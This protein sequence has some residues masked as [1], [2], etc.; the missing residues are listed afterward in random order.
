MHLRNLVVSAILGA[1]ATAGF[2]QPARIRSKIDNSKT[3]VLQG[4]VHPLA[5]SANDQGVVDPG[6]TLPYMT[7]M[8]RSTP[9][10][11]AS[12]EQ[13]LRD[14]QNPASPK[15]HQWLTPEQYADQFGVSASDAAQMVTWLQS[16]GFTV[17]P[18][19]RSRTFITFSGTVGQVQN[20]FGTTITHSNVNG[21]MHYANASDLTIPAELSSVVAGFRGLNDFHPK[22]R[23]AKAKPNWTMGRGTYVIAPDDFATIYDIT[24]LYTAGNNGAGQKVAV[25]G[26]SAINPADINA[27]WTKFG[28]TSVKL[29]QDLVNPR[30]NPGYQT[31]TGDVDESSLDVEWAGAVARGGTVVFVYSGDVWTS[32]MYAVDQ[33][34]APVLSMSYGECEMYDLADLPSYRQ[35]VQQANAQGI[36]WLAAAGDQGATDCDADAT[37]AEGGLAVDEPGS[38]PEV[39]SMGGTA[40]SASASYWNTTNSGTFLSAK[41]YIPEIVWNDTAAA[42]GIL[43]T[44]GGASVFFQQPSWQTNG[45]VP[46]DGWRHV[47][48][49]SFN[50]SVYTVPY[51]VYCSVCT[52]SQQG[53]EYVGGTSAATPTMAGVVAL[54]NQYLNTPGLGNINPG[55]YSLFQST[56]AAFHNNITGNN[57]EPCAYA[58]PGC[59]NGVEGFTASGSGYSSAVGLGSLDVTQ[60]IQNW[61]SA[62][63]SGPVV[64]ASLDQN[65]VYQG[66]AESCG[67]A[68][69][70][71]FLLTLQETA[72]FAT[73]VTSFTVNGTNYTSQL[74]QILGSTTLGA[75]QVIQ[76]CMSLSG[77][78]APENVTFNFSGPKWS[79]SISV[80]FQGPQTQ[81]NVAGVTNAASY[82][83][84]YAPG[85]ILA[86]FGTGMGSL[87]QLASTVPLP[88]YMAGV[89]AGICPVSCNS[90]TYYP[91][92]LYY[93]GPN[94]V[95]IQIPYEVTGP[96]DLNIGNPYALFDF[97][98]TV[99]SVAPGIFTMEDGSGNLNPSTT[100]ARGQTTF[101]FITG[102]GRVSPSLADGTSPAAG[103]PMSRLPKPVSSVTVTVGNVS[104]P[105]TFVGIPSGLVGVTQINFTLPSTV[106]TGRQPVVVTVGTTPTQTA[107]ITVQ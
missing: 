9:A 61:K 104:C 29:V 89:E 56:P 102:D 53:V 11:Q 22:A 99:Q 81:L 30:Q 7:M 54:M 55:I 19:S 42:G 100:A 82:Q 36:T 38:I 62:A 73:T 79:T 23:I 41:G 26:Q 101:L 65:P 5:V 75:R 80:P 96:V 70:W 18:V 59:N 3:S 14:Q 27:F 74:K 46:N 60:F 25:V 13:L 4:R 58:S 45:G 24:P 28:L 95:N 98:F 21:A 106:P 40:V 20:A 93:V 84:T 8:L 52:D 6:F 91:V 49:I 103:T 39:T 67:T 35:T 94:Q 33:N 78:T 97:Y 32:A 10:Q 47:P 90:G 83:Q 48:D 43:A 87:A 76:G 57:N 17:D 16:Q 107:Y 88:E 34:V 15:Y 68:S 64:V 85:M 72:G 2:A 44:G 69:S 37:V 92:P 71:N 12:L 66:A 105:T 31:R 63:P 86:V 1:A 77:V 50:A 51:Y